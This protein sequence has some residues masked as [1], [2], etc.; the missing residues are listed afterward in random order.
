M[1]NATARAVC[2]VYETRLMSIKHQLG[3]TQTLRRPVNEMISGVN[4][5]T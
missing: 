1:T 4:R 3:A 5:E 2:A